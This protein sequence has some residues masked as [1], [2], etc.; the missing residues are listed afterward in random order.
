MSTFRV[1]LRPLLFQDAAWFADLQETTPDRWVVWRV[2]TSLEPAWWKEL[3]NAAA[4]F[5]R[6][7][8]LLDVY[9]RRFA[10]IPDGDLRDSAASLHRRPATA[11]IWE[12]ANELIVGAYLERALKWTFREHEPDG[13]R[14]RVGD[15]GYVAPSGRDVFVE[16]K[17]VLEPE[18]VGNQVFSRGI[19]SRRLT[20]VLKGAYHQLPDDG[21][22][23]LVVVVGNGLILQVSHGIMFG[24]LFQT[25]YGQMQITFQV[26]PYVEGSER[27][28]PAFREMFAHATKHRRLGCVAGLPFGGLDLPGLGF[29]AIHNPF[30]ED[31]VKLGREDFHETRR[32][33]V[34]EDGNGEELPGISPAEAWRRI[35]AADP[36]CGA[37]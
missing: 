33:W 24:D 2:T 26:L 28:G 23:T 15:W 32:F 30:A 25:L 12:I 1:D 17:S 37:A 27:M 3:L 34:D 35:C 31:D 14:R 9:R 18:I 36:D 19:A 21:R 8:S 4:S 29:Y 20:A 16:V 22:S 5:A 6:D 13:F 7:H 11:P 10:G